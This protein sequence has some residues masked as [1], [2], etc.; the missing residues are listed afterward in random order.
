MKH[1]RP[2]SARWRTIERAPLY[3]NIKH[4]QL[5]RVIVHAVHFMD[6]PIDG[7]RDTRFLADCV[8]TGL[9]GRKLRDVM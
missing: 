7:F 8:K 3:P 5:S 2:G 9:A 4:G 6:G 1:L